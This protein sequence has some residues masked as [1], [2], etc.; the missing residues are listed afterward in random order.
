M[1]DKK[2]KWVCGACKRPVASP[3]RGGLIEAIRAHE[4]LCEKGGGATFRIE[5]A[6]RRKDR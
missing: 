1:S 5:K 2:P 4:P 3:K 6:D